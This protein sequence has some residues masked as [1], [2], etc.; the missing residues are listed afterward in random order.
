MTMN[1]VENKLNKLIV[2]NI[3]KGELID[4]A[5]LSLAQ[6]K[7]GNQLL[8]KCQTFLPEVNTLISLYKSRCGIVSQITKKNEVSKLTSFLCFFGF[9]CSSSG[10]NDPPAET[11]APCGLVASLV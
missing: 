6:I 1:V 7:M 11:E 8:K 10:R 3:D 4:A 2:G 5:L 9:G